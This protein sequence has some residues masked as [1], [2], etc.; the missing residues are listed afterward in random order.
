MFFKVYFVIAYLLL[1][2]SGL[3]L[4]AHREP[5]ERLEKL[6]RRSKDHSI[7]STLLLGTYEK[8]NHKRDILALD[9]LRNFKPKLVTDKFQLLS[10]VRD[11]KEVYQTILYN[12][13]NLYWDGS[14]GN[15]RNKCGASETPVVWSVAVALRAISNSGNFGTSQQIND[16]LS[17]LNKYKLNTLE[18]AYSAL[19]AQ[20]S[21]VY[22]DD[23][24]QVSWVFTDVLGSYQ[25]LLQLGYNANDLINYLGTQVNP[26][27]GGITWKCRLP[28]VSSILTLEAALAAVRYYEINS[29]PSLLTF[30]I[31]NLNWVFN[32]LL[33][34]DTCF[35]Y[36]GMSADTHGVNKGKLTYTI[37]TAISTMA[38]LSKYDSSYDWKS[39]ALGFALK[40]LSNGTCD[41]QFF[42]SDGA[43]VGILNDSLD[44]SHLLFAGL[45]DLLEL[46]SP[47]SEYE[48]Q[49][50]QMFRDFVQRQVRHLYEK[51]LNS[52]IYIGSACPSTLSAL[53]DFGSLVQIFQDASRVVDGI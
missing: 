49:A 40:A 31:Y 12:L 14:E 6:N 36:D 43:D 29:E 46:T 1:L 2:A 11:P 18:G 34:P 28:Y 8:L 32:N 25:S 35:I 20:D 53:L 30:A 15:W 13:F 4:S 41:N 3:P 45:A 10:P 24:S 48:S 16:I 5:P 27:V 17:A 51:Y 22:N 39:I 23:V 9:N 38:Y 52:D 37:G 19:T 7:D 47:A 50:Y 21:D 26:Q 42:H 33:E 44:H